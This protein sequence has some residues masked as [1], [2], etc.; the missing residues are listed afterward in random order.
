MISR[1]RI[2][3]LEG[4]APTKFKIPKEFLWISKDDWLTELEKLNVNEVF[5]VWSFLH[6][7]EGNLYFPRKEITKGFSKPKTLNELYKEILK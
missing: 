7:N 5:R 1:K 4:K 3:K 6:K 2:E